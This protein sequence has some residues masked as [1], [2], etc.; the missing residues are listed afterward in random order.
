DSVANALTLLDAVEGIT[1]VLSD[2]A[3]PGGQSGYDLAKE[4]IRSRPGVKIVLMTGHADTFATKSI[5]GHTLTILRKPF[6]I[7]KLHDSIRDVSA[8]GASGNGKNE[9]ADLHIGR[10]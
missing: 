5:Q 10:Q 6:D 8:T 4:I 3:M 9:N 7:K 2:I 1:F